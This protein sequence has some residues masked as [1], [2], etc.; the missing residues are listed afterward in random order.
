MVIFP[1]GRIWGAL[2]AAC[3][4]HEDIKLGEYTAKRLLELEPDN[5]GYHTLLSNVQASVG[6]W[7]EVEDNPWICLCR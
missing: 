5:I 6:H 7:G 2:L 4:V 3:R 1:D